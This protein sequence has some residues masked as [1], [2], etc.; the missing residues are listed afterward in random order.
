[1]NIID[2]TKNGGYRF[3]QF[4]LRKMQEAYF[5]VLKMFV[6]FCNI[7]E[8]GNYIISGCKVVD[9]NI[10][11]GYLYIDGE[12]CKFT[13]AAGIA[14][15]KIKKNVVIQSLG[16]K[17][18]N[19]ENVFRFVDA[20]IDDAGTALSAFTRI[21]PVFDANY[22]NFSQ[23]E[24]TKLAG[25][26]DGAE[27][28]VQADWN[29]TNSELDSFIKNKPDIISPL[30][31]GEFSGI[32][33]VNGNASYV[34]P[35]GAPIASD[36]YIVLGSFF[37]PLATNGY[38]NNNLVFSTRNHTVNDFEILIKETSS[39]SQNVDFHYMIIPKP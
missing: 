29:A 27:A 26:E 12:L 21:A 34:I 30:K 8:V 28:N 9:T 3:K 38:S 39:T 18:G 11:D 37:A 24:K 6:S 36:E 10:T 23:V 20:I 15:S 16:F 22:N 13:Q 5:Q 19:N 32:A 14:S 1:M 7:P 35:F 17:N 2:F 4:T 31:I 33:D 25:I